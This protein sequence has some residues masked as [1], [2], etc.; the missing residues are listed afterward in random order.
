MT[1]TF[2]CTRR[3]LIRDPDWSC[4]DVSASNDPAEWLCL[5]TQCEVAALLGLSSRAI[6][7]WEAKGKTDF[8]V[9]NGRKR[10]SLGE[11]RRLLTIRMTGQRFPSARMERLTLV[12]WAG[13]KLRSGMGE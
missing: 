10:Y 12:S 2:N 4:I 7:Y 6:R 13:Q 3:I 1:A 9:V 11:I 8:K 5:F